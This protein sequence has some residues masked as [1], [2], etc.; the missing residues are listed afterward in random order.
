VKDTGGNGDMDRPGKC[1][2]PVC[3]EEVFLSACMR[4]KTGLA[5]TS[6]K[7]LVRKYHPARCRDWDNGRK[8]EREENRLTLSHRWREILSRKLRDDEVDS[9]MD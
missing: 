2:G 9:R 7:V 1:M 3:W 8:E 5:T 6:L 4:V